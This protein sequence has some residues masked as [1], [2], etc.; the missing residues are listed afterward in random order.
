MPAT[1]RPRALI[2]GASRGIVR[3][4]ALE[5]ARC[6]YD[7]VLAARDTEALES[8][9]R[10][11]A[12]FGIRAEAMALDVCDDGSVSQGV[13]RALA[14]GP[15]DALVNNAGVFQQRTFLAQDPA[16]RQ[17]EMDVS[18]FGAQRVTAAVLPA[19]I[20]R[21]LGTMINVSSLVAAIPCPSVANYC[22]SKAA[23]NA[24]SHALRGE[25]AQ[26][27]IRVVVFLPSHTDIE[28]ASV[29]TRFDGVP[30]LSVEYTAGQLVRSLEQAPR[31]Y[32]ASPVFRAFVRLAGAFPHWVM[33]ASTAFCTARAKG[34]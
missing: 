34:T 24:W 32:V 6:G 11:A 3:A 23:L 27:G 28:Q 12:H 20:A 5:L 13:A 16:W 7:L 25:V 29:S 2:T 26:F 31:Q 22:G 4:A 9:R 1:N 17:R 14:G 19:M 10:E 21:Q 30:G 8:A 18:Y 15:L 33:R